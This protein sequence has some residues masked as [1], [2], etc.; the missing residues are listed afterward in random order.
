MLLVSSCN[1]SIVHR[2]GRARCCERW[3]HRRVNAD[4]LIPPSQA[5]C[6]FV[7]L[8]DE[9]KKE[10]AIATLR[11]ENK[12]TT[13]Q[14]KSCCTCLW[15]MLPER[16]ALLFV[17]E[18]SWRM[19][20]N[21]S[22]TGAILSQSLLLRMSLGHGGKSPWLKAAYWECFLILILCVVHRKDKRGKRSIG[23]LYHENKK[24]I[25][26]RHPAGFPGHVSLPSG[27]Q[28]IFCWERLCHI[29]FLLLLPM[30]EEQFSVSVVSLL[31]NHS[32]NLSKSCLY[33]FVLMPAPSSKLNCPFFHGCVE[34]EQPLSLRFA[35]ENKLFEFPFAWSGFSAP[36][37]QL[38]NL[39]L[40]WG[41]SGSV[42][43]LV[44]CSSYCSLSKALQWQQYFSVSTRNASPD[45]SSNYVCF[46]FHGCIALPV[47]HLATH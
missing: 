24:K 6:R 41:C 27:D 21:V 28:I 7:L 16:L 29:I 5:S 38:S 36:L 25:R 37:D 47:R 18:N 35:M 8:G 14:Y 44:Q 17:L 42:L 22:G 2:E 3:E 46:F 12:K 30:E 11:S 19:R 1:I 9:E 4:V 34:T 40:H 15:N 20:G 26:L 45:S 31:L 23:R 39:P 32:Q 33:Q 43:D 13:S 10:E